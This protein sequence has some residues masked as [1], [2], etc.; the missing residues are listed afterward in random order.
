MRPQGDDLLILANRNDDRFSQKVR[1]L[2][3][4][5]TFE[6]FGY[7]NYHDRNIEITELGRQ[8]LRENEEFLRYLLVN[9]FSYQDI[10][11][12]LSSIEQ[13]PE[14]HTIQTFDENTVIIEGTQRIVQSAVYTRSRQLRDFAIAQFTEDGRIS[15]RACLFNFQ[16]FYGE[17]GAGFIEIHHVRPVFQYEGQDTERTLEQAIENLCPICSNCHRIVHRNRATTMSIDNLI[18]SIQNNGLYNGHNIF[19]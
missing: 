12:S 3:A 10:A 13:H 4:H 17:I 8:H 15:C 18:E 1:N 2:I 9:D 16:D 5:K 19:G 7:A 6:R 11:S 14:R